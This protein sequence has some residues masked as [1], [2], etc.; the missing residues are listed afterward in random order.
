[1]GVESVLTAFVCRAEP[2]RVDSVVLQTFGAC[3]GPHDYFLDVGNQL[4]TTVAPGDIDWLS[5]GSAFTRNRWE[6]PRVIRSQ[7]AI[8]NLQGPYFRVPVQLQL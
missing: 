1:M 2:P 4:K 3:R 8:R 7:Y 5:G 6:R